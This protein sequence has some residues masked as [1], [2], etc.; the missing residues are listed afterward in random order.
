VSDPYSVLGVS[1]DA[2]DDEI[3]KAYRTLARK[4][5]PDLNPG[6]TAAEAKMKEI[7]SAYDRIQDIRSGKASADYG[8]Y[9]SSAG[10]S[11]GSSRGSGSSYRG[12]YGTGF[13]G[14]NSAWNSGN[15]SA[16]PDFEEELRRAY[17][18]AFEAQR[19]R[20][21]RRR[22]ISPLLRLILGLIIFRIVI[23]AIYALFGGF[24]TDPS[25][26]YDYFGRSA[27]DAQS[28]GA[29]TAEGVSFSRDSGSDDSF[30]FTAL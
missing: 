23:T 11:P 22:Q 28:S 7:N 9:R 29:A 12:Y 2:S 21:Y 5:H 19:I 30:E 16:D 15:Y 24:G 8:S 4:Y 26:Y 1:R 3:T 18:R 14:F 27:Q 20:T 13:G 6:N 17:Q 25:G 10:G